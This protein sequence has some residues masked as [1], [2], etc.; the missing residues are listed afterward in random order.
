[1]WMHTTHLQTGHLLA[2]VTFFMSTR[3][4]KVNEEGFSFVC[5]HIFHFS[6]VRGL[7]QMFALEQ[8][9]NNAEVLVKYGRM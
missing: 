6:R 3:V 9:Q 2:T 4:V 7:L 8:P 1:M 5:C